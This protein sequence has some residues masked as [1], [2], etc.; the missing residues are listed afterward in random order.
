MKNE[1]I[2]TCIRS[3]F[4]AHCGKTHLFGFEKIPLIPI[5]LKKLGALTPVCDFDSFSF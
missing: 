1:S 4:N 3:Y 2:T 5:F